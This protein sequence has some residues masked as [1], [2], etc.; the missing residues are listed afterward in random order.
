MGGVYPLTMWTPERLYKLIL[1]KG[2]KERASEG[3]G[4]IDSSRG[5][6]TDFASSFSSSLIGVGGRGYGI[7]SSGSNHDP[8]VTESLGK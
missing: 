5:R 3:E 6:T 2:F 8:F 7:D 1:Q 4:T